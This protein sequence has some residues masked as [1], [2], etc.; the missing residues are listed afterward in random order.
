MSIIANF[1]IFTHDFIIH[2]I[3]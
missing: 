3:I 1:I 2:L